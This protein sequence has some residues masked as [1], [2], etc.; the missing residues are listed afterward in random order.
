MLV[1]NQIKVLA[2]LNKTV[3]QTWAQLSDTQSFH[4]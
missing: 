1:Y 2:V 4:I 3:N